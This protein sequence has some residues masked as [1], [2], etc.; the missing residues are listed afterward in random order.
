MISLLRPRRAAAPAQKRPAYDRFVSGQSGVTGC[1]SGGR[2]PTSPEVQGSGR[3]PGPPGCEPRAGTRPA[4]VRAGGSRRPA[5]RY[6]PRANSRSAWEASRLA[7]CRIS[8]RTYRAGATERSGALRRPYVT[9]GKWVRASDPKDEG[10]RP[11][12][13]SEKKLAPMPANDCR[14]P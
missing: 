10:K 2:P 6:E 8:G 3:A 4:R 1:E 13:T 9:Q 12:M 11:D 14:P 7:G 5:R